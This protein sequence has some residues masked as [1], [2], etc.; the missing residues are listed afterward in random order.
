VTSANPSYR[1]HPVHR[2][3]RK[4][5]RFERSGIVVRF[6]QSRADFISAKK[7]QMRPFYQSGRIFMRCKVDPADYI[8]PSR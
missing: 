6:A 8:E 4:H 7:I 3:S 5:K 1:S 2:S